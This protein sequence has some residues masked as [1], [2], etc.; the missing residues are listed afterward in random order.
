MINT[1]GFS[2][3]QDALSK[4]K[5]QGH[6]LVNALADTCLACAAFKEHIPTLSDL[7]KSKGVQVYNIKADNDNKEFFE[8]YQCETLPYTFVFNNGEFVGGDSFDKDSYAQL[9]G[10]LG[11]IH[12]SNQQG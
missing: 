4:I 10:A 3:A 9:L 12:E 6:I 1:I 8:K 5:G 11:E 2:Q 7:A